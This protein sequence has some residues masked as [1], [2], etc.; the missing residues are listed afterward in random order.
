MLINE[1]KLL[2]EYLKVYI[3][4][5]NLNHNLLLEEALLN[6]VL[7]LGGIKDK[8]KSM[9]SKGAGIALLMSILSALPSNVQAKDVHDSSYNAIPKSEV[10]SVLNDYLE[11]VGLQDYKSFVDGKGNIYIQSTKGKSTTLL[12]D[13]DL[14]KLEQLPVDFTRKDL[15]DR[16]YIQIGNIDQTKGLTAQQLYQIASRGRYYFGLDLPSSYDAEGN[17][18]PSGPGKSKYTYDNYLDKIY[19]LSTAAIY[20]LKDEELETLDDTSYGGGGALGQSWNREKLFSQ[21]QNDAQNNINSM[22]KEQQKELIDEFGSLEKY[23]IYTG[24]DRAGLLYVLFNDL[25]GE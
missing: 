5:N 23:V 11:E 15:Y 18:D 13:N 2:R 14:K 4:E 8:I 7:G 21:G 1:E 3:N 10:V 12:S 19:E 9:T 17:W 6:E 24:L 25:S 16:G 22:S 20:S